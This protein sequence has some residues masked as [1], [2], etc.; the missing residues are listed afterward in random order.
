MEIPEHTNLNISEN[1]TYTSSLNSTPKSEHQYKMKIQAKKVQGKDRWDACVG[2][3]KAELMPARVSFPD[4]FVSCLVFSEVFSKQPFFTK[5]T[6]QRKS[7]VR[8]YLNCLHRVLF[9][10]WKF[11][12]IFLSLSLFSLVLEFT[13][14]K[15]YSKL[16][17]RITLYRLL[18][19]KREKCVDVPSVEFTS[20]GNSRD[21]AWRRFLN[22]VDRRQWVE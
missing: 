3:I 8:D 6:S 12:T 15:E 17:Y 11:P 9:M 10:T 19:L 22:V 20:R 7:E 14:H 18:W 4:R 2:L 21:G 13:M 16:S 5:I 1:F